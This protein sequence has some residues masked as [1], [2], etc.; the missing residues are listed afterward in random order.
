MS[1]YSIAVDL[2]G[3]NLRVAAVNEHGTL[4]EKLTTGTETHKGRDVVIR[5]MT[6]AISSLMMKYRAAG[7][8]S[9]AKARC[10]S[11]VTRAMQSSGNFPGGVRKP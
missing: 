8:A 9:P 3:T 10:C 6:D 5:D 1:M 2:G 7:G 4:L 11:K